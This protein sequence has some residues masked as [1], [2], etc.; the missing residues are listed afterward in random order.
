MPNDENI[1]TPWVANHCPVAPHTWA[2]FAA[3]P[4]NQEE[5]GTYQLQFNWPCEIV[6]FFTTVVDTG[7]NSELVTP[8]PN[9]ILVSYGANQGERWYSH[10]FEASDLTGTGKL[11]CD[12]AAIDIQVPRLV[13]IV[14]PGAQELQFG[15]RWKVW[16]A[17]YADQPIYNNALIGL[18]AYARKLTEERALALL[19]EL[20]Q[21]GSF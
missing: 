14:L 5:T 10:R 3:L 17:T 16:N 9:D 19:R 15:F 7:R 13:R 12:L 2:L 21:E 6:G 8:V 11:Y 1:T 4:G 18:N 20:Q